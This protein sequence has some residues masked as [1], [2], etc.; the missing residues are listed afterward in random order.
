MYIMTKLKR[1][2]G[3]RNNK[4]HELV[5]PLIFVA[6][7]VAGLTLTIINPQLPCLDASNPCSAILSSL[8]CIY[9]VFIIEVFVTFTDINYVYRPY[10]A[11]KYLWKM[12]YARILPN[13]VLS[14]LAFAWYYHHQRGFWLIPFVALSAIIKWR[15]VW[16]AN[17]GETVFVESQKETHQDSI[18]TPKTLS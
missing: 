6:L 5:V 9:V 15:E 3:Q 10:M 11:G 14:I 1:D 17:N 16:L 18:L 8:A 2:D 7:W 4:Y 13:I 12:V